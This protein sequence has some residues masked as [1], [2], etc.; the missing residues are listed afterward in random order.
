MGLAT[1]DREIRRDRLMLA[2]NDRLAG[3]MQRWLGLS[4]FASQKKQRA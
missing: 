4:P 1:V 3:T 2:G